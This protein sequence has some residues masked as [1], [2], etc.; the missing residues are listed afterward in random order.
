MIAPL[1]V[2]F[3]QSPAQQPVQPPQ[4]MPQGTREPAIAAAK[5][6]D[7]WTR[8]ARGAFLRGVLIAMLLVAIAA[9]VYLLAS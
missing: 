9:L 3:V 5:P 6:A 7:G 8:Q 4:R 1:S 2:R